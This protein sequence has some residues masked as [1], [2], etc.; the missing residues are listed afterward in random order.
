M[1]LMEEINGN[2]WN[3]L[4]KGFVVVPTNGTVKKNGEAVM[5]RGLALQLKQRYPYFPR[6][7]GSVI[8][9]EGNKL[10]RF[11]EPNVV[12]FPVKHNWWEK[13]DILLLEESAKKLHS[14]CVSDM[15]TNFYIPHVGC[16]NGGLDWKDVKPILGKHLGELDNVVIV[17]LEEK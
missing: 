12:S 10:F 15:K 2:I 11:F 1:I 4:S 5:G 7:L 13:A 17:G 3:Y 6:R 16:D 8:S 14:I 9:I